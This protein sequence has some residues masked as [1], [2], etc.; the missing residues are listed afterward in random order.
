[1]SQICHLFLFSSCSPQNLLTC[2]PVNL[3]NL[4]QLRH[5]NAGDNAGL[6]ETFQFAESLRAT[7]LLL[8]EASEYYARA[9]RAIAAII[10]RGAAGGPAAALFAP[11]PRLELSRKT[12]S[13]LT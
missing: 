8:P 10:A 1:V 4:R 12:Q 13:H 11:R 5:F 7:Q 2:L 9:P 3:V 6:R